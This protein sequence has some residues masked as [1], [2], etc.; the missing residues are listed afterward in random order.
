MRLEVEKLLFLIHNF[1]IIMGKHF[2]RQGVTEKVYEKIEKYS[3]APVFNTGFEVKGQWK[4]D[5]HNIHC[6]LVFDFD[7]FKIIEAEAWAESTPF[8]I[9]P[10][11][12]KSISNIVG[13]TVGPGFNR[14]VTENIMGKEG[15]VHLGELVMN[16]VKALVQAASRDKPEWVETAD[17][18]QRWNDWIRMYQDQCIFFSQPGVFENS[19]EEIQTAFRSKK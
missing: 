2:F 4:D 17:Y 3:V 6:R 11:G 8:P 13:S 15:C 7:S 12:L 9:C 18:T 19:Q 14:I 5:L 10:Q 16:S 1:P